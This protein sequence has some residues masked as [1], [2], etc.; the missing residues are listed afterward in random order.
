MNN[1]PLLPDCLWKMIDVTSAPHR[2]YCRVS[3]TIYYSH[4]YSTFWI[5]TLL[6][7]CL[8]FP[9]MLTIIL[10]VQCKHRTKL[11]QLLPLNTVSVWTLSSPAS[12]SRA[13]FLPR[14]WRQQAILHLD[15]MFAGLARAGQSSEKR[16]ALHSFIVNET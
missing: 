7:C 16:A 1:G 6:R 11:R 10:E 9:R 3:R 4:R 15:V 14:R 13:P 8:N 5:F 2:S 12:K